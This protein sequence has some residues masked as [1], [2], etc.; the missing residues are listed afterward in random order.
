MRRP[1]QHGFTG[2][3]CRPARAK[4]FAH[5]CQLPPWVDAVGA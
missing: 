5:R 2:L 1:A 3:H 4:L